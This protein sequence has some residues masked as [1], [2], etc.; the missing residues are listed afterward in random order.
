[1]KL[2]HHISTGYEKVHA[3]FFRE[4]NSSCQLKH[5]VLLWL[6]LHYLLRA[7]STNCRPLC[8][9]QNRPLKFGEKTKPRIH[10]IINFYIC[11]FVMF[12]KYQDIILLSYYSFLLLNQKLI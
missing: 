8:K 3:R 5:W 11:Y 9:T 10:L 6:L 7:V 1:M 4:N 12:K 2:F